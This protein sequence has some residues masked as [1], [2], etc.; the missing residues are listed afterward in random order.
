LASLLRLL[1]GA[2]VVG[3]PPPH[4]KALAE[5][6]KTKAVVSAE[7]SILTVNLEARRLTEI[8]LGEGPDV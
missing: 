8:E 1:A 7:K 3:L 6:A 5:V 2:Y 4:G